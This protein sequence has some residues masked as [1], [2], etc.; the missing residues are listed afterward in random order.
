MCT[1][2]H[3][4][5]TIAVA[6]YNDSPTNNIKI[7]RGQRC[8]TYRC[9]SCGQD[10]YAEEPPED[11]AG[12]VAR[13]DMLVEDEEQLHEAEDEVKRQAEEDGDRRCR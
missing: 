4:H 7:W 11:L 2:C 8:C 3:G 5:H 13:D 9:L 1:S 12:T 10:F 6:S